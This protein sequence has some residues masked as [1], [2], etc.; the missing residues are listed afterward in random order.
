MICGNIIKQD[1][2]SR[3]DFLI[4][5]RF[6]LHPQKQVWLVEIE[7][8]QKAVVKFSELLKGP[9]LQ[10]LQICADNK[11]APKL[12]A[13]GF[14]GRWCVTVSQYVDGDTIDVHLQQLTR[15]KERAALLKTVKNMA[16][17]M[18]EKLK[19][20]HGDLRAPNILVE[21]GTGQVY[22]VDW[23]FAGELE[24]A[25]YPLYLNPELDWPE[26]VGAGQMI[27]P[28]HD[29]YWLMKLEKECL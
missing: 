11:L 13:H 28:E 24:T 1:P 8:Q 3:S 18:H 27:K 25:R 23:D 10:A 2:K 26:G 4:S 12:L 17:M 19:I 22:I 15:K 29:M 6:Q 21:N 14:S 5:A 16:I 20:V 7:N 9:S